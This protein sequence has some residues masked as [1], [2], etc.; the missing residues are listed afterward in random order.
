MKKN[1]SDFK[2]SLYAS[3]VFLL[4]SITSLILSYYDENAI[5]SALIFFLIKLLLDKD[6]EIYFKSHD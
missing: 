5:S 6:R 2:I 3:R 4:L 1:M